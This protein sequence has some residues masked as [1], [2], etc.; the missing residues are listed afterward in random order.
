MYVRMT[1]R[2]V[3]VYETLEPLMKDYR[4]LRVR[5][6]GAFPLPDRVRV[7]TYTHLP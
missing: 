5:S 7:T 2:A 6:M 1:F 3:D 4:K